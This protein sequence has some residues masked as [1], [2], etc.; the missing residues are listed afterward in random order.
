MT[1]RSGLDGQIG[2]KSESTVGTAVTVDHFVE[3]DNEDFSYEPT[4]LEGEGIR[5]GG[6]YKRDSRVGVVRKDVNGKLDHKLAT[7]NMGLLVKH[8]MASAATPVQIGVTTAYQ[9]IHTPGDHYGKGLTVQVGR[10]EPGTGTVRPFT[11]NGCKC[12]SWEFSVTDG[13]HA[14]LSTTWDGWNEDTATALA[15]A[16]YTASTSL[17]NFSHASLT[18]GGTATTGGSPAQ[19]SVAGSTAAATVIN[20]VTIRGEN[21]MKA[22]RYGIGNAGIKS[23]QL[24]NDYPTITGTIAAEFSKV[25]LYDVFKASTS[26]TMQLNMSQ[27]DAGGSNAFAFNWILPAA[28]FKT[29]APSVNGPD[30]VQMNV[31]F[32]V[33]DDGTNAVAQVKIVS[34]DTAL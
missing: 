17:F 24:E 21:P 9:Q 30:I 27:G 13:A 7:K 11:Y 34:T 2:F 10:P 28:R 14:M 15:T 31:D 29:A 5:A 1:T 16:S 26:T 20:S 3:F 4:W 33:Y 6:K 23:E 25:E 19:I 8:M 22:D 32:E 12:T 18:L